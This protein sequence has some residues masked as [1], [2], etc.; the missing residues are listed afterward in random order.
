MEVKAICGRISY[1]E[2]GKL[3]FEENS[4]GNELYI[5]E[6]GKVEILK[7]INGKNVTI[8]I[9]GKGDIFG[10]TAIFSDAPRTKSA[11][12]IG[13]TVLIS[14][15]LEELIYRMQTNLQFAMNVLQSLMIRLQNSDNILTELFTKIQS[16]S[17]N[18]IAEIYHE[19][20]SLKIGEIMIEMEYITRPQLER[21]ILRQKE[22]HIFGYKWQLLG[23]ILIEL[24][25][26]TE[27][28]LRSA[29]VEQKIRLRN[30]YDS[31]EDND[32]NG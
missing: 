27:D 17:N 14:F 12:A 3:I 5:I 4:I 6:S 11:K 26:I 18:I 25:F 28:Q 22:I 2:D 15:T 23:K 8:S 13:K 32:L 10:E 1:Y 24:G 31:L 9:L 7:R 29:L 21:A 19:K 16:F 20:R 30:K